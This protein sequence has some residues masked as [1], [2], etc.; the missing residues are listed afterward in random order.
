MSRK[1]LSRSTRLGSEPSTSPAQHPCGKEE[2]CVNAPRGFDLGLGRRCM[3]EILGCDRSF[4]LTHSSP[5]CCPFCPLIS[6][7]GRLMHG[8]L[9]I[10]R[11]GACGKGRRS[12][13]HWKG[14]KACT[15]QHLT[16]RCTPV[17]NSHQDLEWD[18]QGGS[19]VAAVD[20]PPPPGGG[21]LSGDRNASFRCPDRL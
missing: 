11:T 4:C 21:D 19:A 1:H 10:T 2:V 8:K 16:Q 14:G 12:R 18:T 17:Q 5:S 15:D 13:K 9:G 3:S 20:W 7:P 6:H